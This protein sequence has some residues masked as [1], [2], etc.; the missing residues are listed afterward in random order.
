MPDDLEWERWQDLQLRR[1]LRIER[2]L[3]AAQWDELTQ[4]ERAKET[5]AQAEALLV[6]YRKAEAEE[7]PRDFQSPDD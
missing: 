6:E 5:E 1:W 3:L 4:P 7:P 2:L